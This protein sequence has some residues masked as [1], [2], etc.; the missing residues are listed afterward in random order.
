MNNIQSQ[1]QALPNDLAKNCDREMAEGE[2]VEACMCRH[3]CM[4][5]L[6]LHLTY[7]R[8]VENVQNF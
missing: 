6:N 3:V 4:W 8:L 5:M 2:G 7:R 1:Q